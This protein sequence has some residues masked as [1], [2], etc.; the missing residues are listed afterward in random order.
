ME[1]KWLEDFVSLA[2]TG[3]FSRSAL[4]RNVTQPAFSRRIQSLEAWVGVDLIDRTNY[5]TRLTQ[6]GQVFYEQALA[7]LDQLNTSRALL[8][9][10][11]RASAQT[12]ELA[13]PHTL[14]FVFIPKWL[15]LIEKKL[16]LNDPSR[17][18]GAPLKSRLLAGNVHDAVL[19]LAEG[20][21]DL[22]ICYHHPSI[23]VQLDAQRYEMKVLGTETVSA[24]ARRD[25]SGG[26]LWHL[27]GKANA[28]VPVLTYTSNAYIGRVVEH[29]IQKS[30]P[31]LNLDTVYE[32]DISEALKMMALE[33]QGVVWLPD[34][35]AEREVKRKTLVMVDQRYRETVEIRAYRERPTETRPGKPIALSFW[36]ALA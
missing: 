14:S 16:G 2:E 10:Q 20:G 4:L 6:A 12:L 34:M 17:K 29:I 26:P 15:K 24:Y 1:S 33:G 19:A 8:R 5:P 32:T 36:S 30:K 23:P 9:G 31:R 21:C 3:S 27:P 13:V 28:P 18:L 22:L 7:M 25:S 35:A 11:G